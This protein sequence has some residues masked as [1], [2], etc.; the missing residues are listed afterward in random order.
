LANTDLMAE[1][2]DNTLSL[3]LEAAPWLLLG[4]VLAGLIRALIP[5]TLMQRWLG[6]SGLW[7]VTKAAVVGAPIPLCSCG[8]VPA[9]LSLRNSGASKGSTL[10]FMIATPETGVDSVAVTYALMGPFMAVTR[11]IASVLTAIGVGTATGVAERAGVS[12]APTTTPT[13]PGDLAACCSDGGCETVPDTGT[14]LSRRISDGLRYAFFDLYDEIVW[15]LA[16]GL[17]VAG[18]VVTFLSPTFLA[19]IGSG[20]IAKIV[21]FLIGIP[22]YICA[23]ASTPLAASLLLAGVSPGTVLVF[24]LAGPATNLG[25]LGIL[26][27]EF[28]ARIL[29]VYLVSLAALTLGAGIVTDWAAKALSIDLQTQ[30]HA[31]EHVLPRWLQGASATALVL[32]AIPPLRRSIFSLFIGERGAGTG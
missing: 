2:I 8:V 26:R 22:M 11:P 5:E 16:L 12:V 9:A 24:L 25:T 15:W 23:T 18:A 20:L 28:G 4:M 14:S 19:E 29:T 27:R 31:A 32:M 7:P 6:G 10:S 13:N 21:M 30:L 17:L 3:A 1:L